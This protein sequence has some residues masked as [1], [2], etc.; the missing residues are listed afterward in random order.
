MKRVSFKS[1]LPFGV[2]L[3]FL[4]V[5]VGVGI[6]ILVPSSLV[7]VE[8]AITEIAIL[9]Y[10]SRNSRNCRFWA[11]FLVLLSFLLGSVEESILWFFF[12]AKSM[13]RGS[14]L[15]VVLSIEFWV[16][17]MGIVVLGS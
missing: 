17:A 15:L 12:R 10:N 1:L 11:V 9:G 7:W 8:V 5:G 4:F 14:N 13:L 2:G 3:Y 6:G 16:C